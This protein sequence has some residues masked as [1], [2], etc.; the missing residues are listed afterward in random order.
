M[1]DQHAQTPQTF[2]ARHGGFFVRYIKPPQKF[3]LMSQTGDTEWSQNGRFTGVTDIDLTQKGISQVCSSAKALV[4]KGKLVDP[5]HISRIYVSPRRR[6][7]HTLE[8]L[9]PIGSDLGAENIVL[10][11]DIAEWNYGDYEGL[12]DHEIRLARKEKGLDQGSEWDLWSQGCEAGEYDKSH[13]IIP[14]I[15]LMSTRS[16]QQV[17]ERLDRLILEIKK[18]QEPCMRGEAPANVLIVSEFLHHTSMY[19]CFLASANMC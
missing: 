9:L 2:I 18:I 4:G 10:T 15:L 13:A 11:E 12:K 1:S 14:L 3:T 8:L 7:V 16:P 17:S 19:R 6:A 5:R